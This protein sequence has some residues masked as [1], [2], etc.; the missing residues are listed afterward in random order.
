MV[1]QTAAEVDKDDRASPRP[2]I[3]AKRRLVRVGLCFQQARQ[4]Q[5]EAGDRADAQEVTPA[6]TVTAGP[7]PA[8]EDIEHDVPYLIIH[9]LIGYS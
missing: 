6:H 3:A 2:G 1:R 8:Q 5:A 7:L 4:R 9:S